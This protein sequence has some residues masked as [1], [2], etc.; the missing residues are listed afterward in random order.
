MEGGLTKNGSEKVHIPELLISHYLETSRLW[1]TWGTL[2][3]AHLTEETKGAD[4]NGPIAILASIGIISVFGWAYILALTF[5]IQNFE[6]LYDPN[7]ETAGAFVPA[8]ILYDAFHGRYHNSAGAIVLLFVI[9]GSFFFG[10]L[11]ITTSAPRVLVPEFHSVPTNGIS[12]NSSNRELHMDINVNTRP[13]YGTA[14][15]CHYAV[16]FSSLHNHCFENSGGGLNSGSCYDILKCQTKLNNK[17]DDKKQHELDIGRILHGEDSRTTLMIKN[18]P[19][20]YT[21]KILLAAIDENHR[22]TYDFIYLPIDFK[23][24]HLINKMNIPTPPLPPQEPRWSTSTIRPTTSYDNNK[25]KF[26]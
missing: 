22:G 16:G 4:K 25:S 10:G 18:I 20:K 7:N 9:W 17:V 11:S 12:Y 2:K 15:G 13:A 6:Y 21:L 23:V 19:N 1:N 24:L 26:E 14:K 8:Q 3:A 5:S